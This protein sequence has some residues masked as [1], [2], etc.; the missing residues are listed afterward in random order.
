MVTSTNFLVAKIFWLKISTVR[1]MLLLLYVFSQT[2]RNPIFVC[3]CIHIWSVCKSTK[4]A[5]LLKPCVHDCLNWK[6]KCQK[7][8]IIICL[9]NSKRLHLWCQMVNLFCSVLQAKALSWAVFNQNLC[10]EFWI[11][12]QFKVPCRFFCLMFCNFELFYSSLLMWG[13][14]SSW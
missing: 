1:T 10:V 11:T 7:Y 2:R 9:I 14:L 6:M 13:M 12:T 4:S 5:N 3:S 8:N